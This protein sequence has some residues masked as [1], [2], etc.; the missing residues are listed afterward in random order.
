MDKKRAS[1]QVKRAEFIKRTSEWI[2]INL[3]E[4]Q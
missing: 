2:N 1:E 4:S 3:K